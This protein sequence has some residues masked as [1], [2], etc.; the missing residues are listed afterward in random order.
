MVF[1]ETLSQRIGSNFGEPMEFEATIFPGFT[2][3]WILDEIQ[4]MM[5]ELRCEPEQFQ[6]K[7]HFCYVNVQWHFMENTRKCRKLCSEFFKRCSICQQV[8]PHGCWSF[9][10]LDCEKK[11]YGTHVNKPSGECN[12]VA[13][14]M[15]INFAESGHPMF[16][17]TSALGKRRVEK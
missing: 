5:A 12:R 15:M 13:E 14:S 7:D 4:N 17:A 1:G 2:S 11:S 6:R 8:H 10:G 9:L 3:L 16:Q